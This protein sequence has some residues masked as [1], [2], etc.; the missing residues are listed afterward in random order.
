MAVGQASTALQRR[1]R[2]ATEAERDADRPAGG[3]HRIVWPSFSFPIFYEVIF[4]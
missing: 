3:L 1:C 2:R 4:F